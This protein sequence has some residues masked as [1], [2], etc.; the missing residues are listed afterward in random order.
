MVV[1]WVSSSFTARSSCTASRSDDA[2]PGGSFRAIGL[3]RIVTH[4]KIEQNDLGAIAGIARENV[5]RVL[6]DWQRHKAVSRLSGYYCIE[7]NAEL[8][9]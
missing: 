1:G 9:N 2:R 4:Q 5:T 3:A 6:N 8:E 7:N